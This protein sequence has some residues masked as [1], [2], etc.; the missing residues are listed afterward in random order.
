MTTTITV[1]GTHCHA[2]KALIEDVCKDVPGVTACAVDPQT[3]RTTLEHE[4]GLDWD[5]LTREIEALGPY[6]VQR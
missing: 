3:G 6:K 5:M 1:L 2:C 4:V